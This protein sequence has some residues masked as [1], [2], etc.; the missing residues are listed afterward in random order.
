MEAEAELVEEVREMRAALEEAKERIPKLQYAARAWSAAS[1]DDMKVQIDAERLLRETL[2]RPDGNNRSFVLLKKSEDSWN[3]ICNACEALGL[4]SLK[5]TAPESARRSARWR[6]TD[7]HW[8]VIGTEIET[9]NAKVKGIVERAQQAS[10]DDGCRRRG[11]AK[12]KRSPSPDSSEADNDDFDITGAWEVTSKMF[13]SA[14]HGNHSRLLMEIY[15]ESDPTENT[16]WA[17]FDFDDVKGMMRLDDLAKGENDSVRYTRYMWLGRETGE[18]QPEDETEMALLIRLY[19]GGSRFKGHF[20]WK[21][22]GTIRF[23]GKKVAHGD[24]VPRPSAPKWDSFRRK[25]DKFKG[26]EDE[27]ISDDSLY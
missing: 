2:Q 5:F 6:T 7:L 19:R 12:R 11:Q 4:H 8:I 18:G 21:S 9:V 24:C 26:S 15:L 10:P 25:Y 16:Y 13:S 14:N 23:S 17:T 22:T 3:P 27:S 1:T 20:S